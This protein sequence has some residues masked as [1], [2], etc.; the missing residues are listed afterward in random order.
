MLETAQRF[1]V[2]ANDAPWYWR[3]HSGR[4]WEMGEHGIPWLTLMA[5]ITVATFI[6]IRSSHGALVEVNRSAN[7]TL[8]Y[9][10]ARWEKNRGE[11]LE[12]RREH[13]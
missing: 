6:L 5:L 3:D 11:Y 2:A 4:F 13:P 12:R 7:S 8:E 10:Y 1:L 9:F